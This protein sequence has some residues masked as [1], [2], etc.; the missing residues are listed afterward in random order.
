[1]FPNVAA[2]IEAMSGS[3]QRPTAEQATPTTQPKRR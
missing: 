3:W 1:M 2:G